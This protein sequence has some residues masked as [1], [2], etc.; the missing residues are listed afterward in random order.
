MAAENVLSLTAGSTTVLFVLYL[1]I[2]GNFLAQLFGCRLQHLLQT[3]MVAKH[4]LGFFTLFFFCMIVDSSFETR[5][6]LVTLSC[7]VLLYTWFVMTVRTKLPFLL[8]TLALLCAA[9]VARLIERRRLA[10]D[11]KRDV[12][13][14][15]LAQKVLAGVA[16]ASTVIGFVIYGLEKRREYRKGFSWISFLLGNTN[17]KN[18]TPKDAKV[19]F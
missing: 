11:E 1:I 2:S 19:S 9:Y 10:I 16:F 3:S 8:V 6:I 5:H 14:L 15:Q 18:F 12:G 13:E 7:S 4:V 17:C